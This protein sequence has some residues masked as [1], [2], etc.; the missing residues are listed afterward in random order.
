MAILAAAPRHTLIANAGGWM[1][2]DRDTLA[3]TPHTDRN[4]IYAVHYYEPG[5]FTHQGAPWMKPMYQPLRNVPWPCDETNL[6]AALGSLVRQGWRGRLAGAD[7]AA[8]GFLKNMVKDGIGQPKRMAENFEQLGGWAK[9]NA[10][11]VVINEF[12]VFP[13]Y[14]ALADRARWLGDVRRAAE[15]HGFGWAVWD[16]CSGF[17]IVTGEPGARQ[18]NP[19]VAAALGLK[20]SASA[21]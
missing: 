21:K 20:V 16:Y 3:L 9:K 11:R 12:G 13:P 8:E 1:T 19:E 10:V 5:Q 7:K 2:W 15:S 4:V 6:Q 17:T 18:F 14:A